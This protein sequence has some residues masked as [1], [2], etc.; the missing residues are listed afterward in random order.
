MSLSTDT[1]LKLRNYMKE[2]ILTTL[3]ADKRRL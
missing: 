1:V 2:Y 3:D